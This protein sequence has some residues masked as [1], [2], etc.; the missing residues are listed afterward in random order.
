MWNKKGVFM[1]FCA[2]VLTKETIIVNV[3]AYLV[4]SVASSIVGL[5]VGSTMRW[6]TTV[7]ST[8][9]ITEGI[10]EGIAL[11]AWWGEGLERENWKTWMRG[12]MHQVCGT[13]KLGG[14][15]KFSGKIKSTFFPP[16]GVVENWPWLVVCTSGVVRTGVAGRMVGLP[17]AE[18]VE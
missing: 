12:Y 1:T 9:G 15:V 16:W 7:V 3:E 13:K 18:A 14:E 10:A 4:S 6:V 5:T 17:L 2:G 8:E 11:V